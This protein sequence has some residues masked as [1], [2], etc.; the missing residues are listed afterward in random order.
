MAEKSK[1]VCAI[2]NDLIDWFDAHRSKELNMEQFYLDLIQH[3]VP[4]GSILDVGCGTGEPLAKFFIAKGYE[5]T[6]VDASIKMI[7]FCKKNYPGKQWLLVDMRD[8]NLGTT[9]DVVI[10]WHSFFHVPLEDQ[11]GTLKLLAKHVKENGLL[12]FTSGPEHGEIWS[13]NGGRDL[14]HASLSCQEYKH[15]L[16]VN[17]F[18]VIAHKIN[19]PHC[20]DATVWV[21]KKTG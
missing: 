16:S 21:A 19:D 18:Q 2:Y 3:H 6:G 17:N 14:Y 7:D 1:N 5:L 10:A 4:Q 11:P 9:F 20:G 13:N 8:L 12:V 15:L